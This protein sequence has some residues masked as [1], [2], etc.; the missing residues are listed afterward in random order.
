VTERDKGSASRG[1]A[2]VTGVTPLKGCVTAV[3]QRLAL[4]SRRLAATPLASARATPVAMIE[5]LLIVT[6]GLVA[7]LE[8]PALRWLS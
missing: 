8:V 5:I 4:P 3:T 2:S 6:L 1:C 7:A